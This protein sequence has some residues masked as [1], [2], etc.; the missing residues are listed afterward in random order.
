VTD[1]TKVPVQFIPQSESNFHR[2]AHMCRKVS[3]RLYCMHLVGA[4]NCF[5]RSHIAT[6]LQISVLRPVQIQHSSLRAIIASLSLFFMTCCL[7]VFTYFPSQ[8]Q[9][10]CS[11]SIVQ[12]SKSLESL[13]PI[14]ES[15]NQ[16]SV[17][18][19]Y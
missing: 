7:S 4:D 16:P 15:H 19:K 18:V 13:T 10:L 9:M 8:P 1:R 2:L 6:W 12:I 11:L 3:A 14:Q 17:S 5:C